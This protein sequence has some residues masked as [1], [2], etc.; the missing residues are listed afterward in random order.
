MENGS[1]VGTLYMI[2]IATALMS[3]AGATA[4]MRSRIASESA[5]TRSGHEAMT[6]SYEDAALELRV[7]AQKTNTVA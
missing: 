4:E 5:V 6:K 7:K 1:F 3:S 2:T